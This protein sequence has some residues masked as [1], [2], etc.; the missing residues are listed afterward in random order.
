[1][2]IFTIFQV[3]MMTTM[4]A[5]MTTTMVGLVT[6]MRPSPV[7]LEEVEEVSVVLEEVGEASVVLGEALGALVDLV[8]QMRDL[9]RITLPMTTLHMRKEF[10]QQVCLQMA[11][12]VLTE[13]LLVEDLVEAIQQLQKML[14]VDQ[15]LQDWEHLQ[16]D[17]G[18][19]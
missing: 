14:R 13:N 4:A 2:Q 6:I 17:L 18:H 3:I 12:V 5:I 15:A 19:L 11:L 1:M 10:K 9:R 16:K 7:A 8:R